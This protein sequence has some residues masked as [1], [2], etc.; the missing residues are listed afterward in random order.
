MLGTAGMTID[1]VTLV[2]LTPLSLMSGALARREIDAVTIWEPEIEL[3]AEAIG[4]DAI[5]FQDRSV[6]RE[7]FNL[8]TTAAALADPAKRREIVAF[9]RALIAATE[10]IRA[11]PSVAWPLVAARN[12]YDVAL[13]ERVWHHEGF[14]G[15]LV[16]DLLDVLVEEDVYLARERGRAPRSRAE[17]A[18]LIDTTVLAEALAGP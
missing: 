15:T 14:P 7:L 4:A 17:L 11:E 6:Y 16:G 3:A 8:N 2:P 1:D 18:E 5:E 10:R 13:I 12:G 9:V